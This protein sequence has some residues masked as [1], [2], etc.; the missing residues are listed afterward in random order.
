MGNNNYRSFIPDQDLEWPGERAYGRIVFIPHGTDQ[1]WVQS[2]SAVLPMFLTKVP[3]LMLATDAA[4]ERFRASF[5]QTM[6]KALDVPRLQSRIRMLQAQIQSA[7]KLLDPEAAK[8]QDEAARELSEGLQKRQDHLLP[9]FS[10]EPRILTVWG[11]RP[12]M[13]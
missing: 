9:Y 3:R 6:S 2:Q 8:R 10:S 1:T 4:C 7:L 5:F 13:S 11:S 12:M